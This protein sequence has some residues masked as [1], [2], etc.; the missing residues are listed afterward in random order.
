MYMYT[1]HYSWRFTAIS[2][3]LSP[4]VLHAMQ[5][6][7]IVTTFFMFAGSGMEICPGMPWTVPGCPMIPMYLYTTYIYMCISSSA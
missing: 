4:E 7:V 2:I 3:H 5:A 6:C 1:H